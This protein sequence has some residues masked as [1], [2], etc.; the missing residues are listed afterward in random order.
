VE[1]SCQ[2]TVH[3]TAT[4]EPQPSGMEAYA[5]AY[6]VYRSLYPLLK[7]SFAAAADL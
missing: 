3:I 5:A 4:T 7:D 6:P 2:A 1:E